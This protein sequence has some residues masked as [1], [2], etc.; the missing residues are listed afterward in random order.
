M[1]YL[2]VVKFGLGQNIGQRP[3]LFVSILFLVASVQFLTTGVLSELMTRTFSASSE[4]THHRIR[5][6]SDPGSAGWKQPA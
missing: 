3:L 6:Q 4:H 5:T 1:A 2:L